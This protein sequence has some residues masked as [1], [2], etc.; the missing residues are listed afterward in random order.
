MAKTFA[1]AIRQH[2]LAFDSSAWQPAPPDSVLMEA[3]TVGEFDWTLGTIK[4]D[5][6]KRRWP[7][8]K[9]AV[10]FQ[11][12]AKNPIESLVFKYVKQEV[13]WSDARYLLA[14]HYAKNGQYHLARKECLAVSRVIP[15]HYNPLLR[16]ADYYRLE[17]KREEARAA[18]K[19][20]LVVEENPYGHVRLGLFYL[21]EENASEAANELQTALRIN[22]TFSDPLR[23]EGVSGARYLLGVAYAKMGRIQEA[24]N[25]L[26]RALAIDPTNEE[27]KEVL[28]QL[29]LRQ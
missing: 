4:T 1:H 11:F 20:C 7:F 9:S 23:T 10:N 26:N 18:Y 15:Y 3:S 13:A 6:L 5:L 19:Q 24:K 12:T 8:N 28:K 29:A 17:G 25:E 14:E 2:H 22:D 16:V 21:E 27:A